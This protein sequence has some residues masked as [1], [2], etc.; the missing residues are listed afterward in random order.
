MRL[1]IQFL[2]YNVN[3]EPTY[4]L[5]LALYVDSSFK[6]SALNVE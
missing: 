5:L 3:R 1:W 4:M 2:R 6:T